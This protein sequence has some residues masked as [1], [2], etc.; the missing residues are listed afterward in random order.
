MSMSDRTEDVFLRV[1][2]H[3]MEFH[4]S[5]SGRRRAPMPFANALHSPSRSHAHITHRT[6]Q[7]AELFCEIRMMRQAAVAIAR[8]A[9]DA[10]DCWIFPKL[11]TQPERESSKTQI[12]RSPFF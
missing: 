7:K 12:S 9:M 11:L 4:H 5:C 6:L 3:S 10:Y 1:A 2:R 8:S